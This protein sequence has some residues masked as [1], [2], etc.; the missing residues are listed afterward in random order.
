MGAFRRGVYAAIGIGAGVFGLAFVSLVFRYLPLWGTRESL[1][2]VLYT[3]FAYV[4]LGGSV[5]GFSPRRRTTELISGVGAVI[6]VLY[7]LGVPYY[8]I[9]GDTVNDTYVGLVLIF[10]AIVQAVF[11]GGFQLLSRRWRE[12]PESESSA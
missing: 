4:S 5:V 8:M 6:A 7:V 2:V 3:S 9:L 10:G 12:T 1:Y 11:I